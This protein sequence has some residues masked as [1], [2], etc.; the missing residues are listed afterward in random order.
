LKL[1]DR[2]GLISMFAAI[3]A[4][5]PAYVAWQ[6]DRPFGKPSYPNI[7]T[8]LTATT[9]SRPSPTATSTTRPPNV[10]TSPRSQHLPPSFPTT[11]LMVNTTSTTRRPLP[12]PRVTAMYAVWRGGSEVH[13]HVV[14]YLGWVRTEFI[15]SQP[16]L[17]SIEVNIV[18]P[19][20]I[21]FY[22]ERHG[23]PDQW[24]R[25]TYALNVPV[26]DNGVTRYVFKRPVRLPVGELLTLQIWNPER[27]DMAVY[28]SNSHDTANLSTYLSCPAGVCEHPGHSLNA[29]IRG[30][31]RSV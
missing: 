22:V 4:L 16:Y 1:A 27:T 9:T 28:F 26:V 14:G 13:T 29:I 3:L 23:S 17:R 24:E 11:S 18:G 15:A 7:P 6:D 21:E 5:P 12:P 30:S 8:T 19:R 10:Q 20:R 31:N 25:I 2:V